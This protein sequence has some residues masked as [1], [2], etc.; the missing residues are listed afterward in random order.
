[1]SDLPSPCI[2]FLPYT[3]FSP[4]SYTIAIRPLRPVTT[5]PEL[6]LLLKELKHEAHLFPVQ[7]WVALLSGHAREF[8]PPEGAAIAAT[9]SSLINDRSR[10]QDHS[11]VEWPNV[12]QENW[13][14]STKPG[15]RPR[16]AYQTQ[17]N[18]GQ[19]SLC[20][21]QDCC[22]AF[23][24]RISRRILLTFIYASRSAIWVWVCQATIEW[25][26]WTS[27]QTI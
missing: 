10:N 5:N 17:F 6:D 26:F 19:S 4:D 13:H 27:P 24:P 2:R 1:M 22:R 3:L 16:H 20:I 25:M 7:Y 14:L 15:H 9:P 8:K 12:F 23:S 18:Q 11:Y 21:R